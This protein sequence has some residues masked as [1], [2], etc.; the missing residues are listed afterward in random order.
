MNSIENKPSADLPQA[1][2]TR[3]NTAQEIL[4]QQR[5]TLLIP[6]IYVVSL[7]GG[8][9]FTRTLNVSF[10]VQMIILV[11]FIG[12]ITGAIE[13][14]YL[15]RRLNAAI[16]LLKQY[17]DRQSRS[18]ANSVFMQTVRSKYAT[19]NELRRSQT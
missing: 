16:E 17:E 10:A 18:F 7:V 15:G 12:A 19:K 4:R 1:P 3:I 8:L 5:A 13:I 2:K 14:Y 6:L 9:H 11:G